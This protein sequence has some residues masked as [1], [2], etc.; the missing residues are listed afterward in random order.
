MLRIE[1]SE[2][3]EKTRQS[4]GRGLGEHRERIGRG[5]NG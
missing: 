5:E 1:N 4:T 3:T 2:N